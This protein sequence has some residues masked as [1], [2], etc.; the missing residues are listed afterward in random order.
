MN[1]QCNALYGTASYRQAGLTTPKSS[2][3]NSRH[4]AFLCRNAAPY[5][6]CRNCI[7]LTINRVT[8]PK[9][10]THTCP[11][12]QPHFPQGWWHYKPFGESYLFSTPN[13]CTK[14]GGTVV[15]SGEAYPSFADNHE[16]ENV[17]RGC[18]HNGTDAGS[19]LLNA[20]LLYAFILS[21]RLPV[22]TAPQNRGDVPHIRGGSTPIGFCSCR[23]TRL[24]KQHNAYCKKRKAI[25]KEIKTK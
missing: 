7:S 21:A 13:N 19:V 22:G 20:S 18:L 8:P 16:W 12:P 9:K 11:I 2:E 15:L 24:Q 5:A 10:K 17:C 1:A 23:G 6:I 25:Q 4:S 3:G 14:S